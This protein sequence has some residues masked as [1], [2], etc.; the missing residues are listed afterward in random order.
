MMN[1]S[2]ATLIVNSLVA[3]VAALKAGTITGPTAL[4]EVQAT[5]ALGGLEIKRQ[6]N[7]AKLIARMEKVQADVAALRDTLQAEADR[8]AAE[9][10]RVNAETKRA[11]DEA[12]NLAAGAE[13]ITTEGAPV[14]KAQRAD[15]CLEALRGGR[16][17]TPR[18]AAGLLRLSGTYA[19][20]AAVAALTQLVRRGQATMEKVD[21]VAVYK[22]A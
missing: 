21:G 19:P 6:A 7:T 1:L 3:A 22:L 9:V 12:H 10:A 17:L 8:E 20:Q 18:E 2:T 15:V 11:E 13:L 5:L 16:P 14:D 4:K